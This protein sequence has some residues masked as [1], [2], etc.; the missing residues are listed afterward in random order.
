[1]VAFLQCVFVE[2]VALVCGVSLDDAFHFVDFARQ[3]PRADQFCQLAVDELNRDSEFAGHRLQFDS[4]VRLQELRVDDDS[5]L[6]D[7][8]SEMELQEGVGP[9]QLDD[10]DENSE[11]V[12]VPALVERVEVLFY[13]GQLHQ[14]HQ[15]F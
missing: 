3:P 10:V 4:F 11:E 12:L 1:M 8:V 14:V 7:E 5:G 13:V 2:S 9:D 15:C 6:S